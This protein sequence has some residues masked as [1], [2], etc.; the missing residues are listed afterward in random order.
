MRLT[1]FPRS[2]RHALGVLA[3]LLVLLLGLVSAS[4][5]RQVQ[6]LQA[7]VEV[8]VEH[9]LPTLRL[10]RELQVQLDELRGLS[11]LQLASAAAGEREAL[12][13]RMQA[14]RQGIERRLAAPLRQQAGSE[15]AGERAQREAAQAGWQRYRA[16]HDRLALIAAQAETD[17]GAGEQA[18]A[19]LAGEAQQ[20]YQ[21]LRGA[22]DA[23]YEA[24]EQRA[25]QARR[26]ASAAGE[27]AG[28]QLLAML[29][30]GGLAAAAGGAW[31]LWGPTV[32]ARPPA[33]PRRG[34]GDA[35]RA[36]ALRRAV[37]A[38][39]RGPAAAA[40]APASRPAP[41]AEADGGQAR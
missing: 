6:A 22:L 4:A 20:A 17:A 26:Q 11:A 33:G 1:L 10:V 39:R 29:V 24:G 16:L 35:V 36:A 12:A 31:G 3:A 21:A 40:P 41:L 28:W 18:R 8:V 37:Q 9:T 15:G 34:P 30:L 19:L 27:A 38:A 13:R 25:A 14:Q 32:P 7:Q 23:W 5:M 2:R